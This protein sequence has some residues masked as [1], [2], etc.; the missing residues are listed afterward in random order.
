[1]QPDV[2]LGSFRLPVDAEQATERRH[3][4]DR[5]VLS[6]RHVQERGIGQPV[7]RDERHAALHAEVRAVR[8][9]LDALDEHLPGAGVAAEDESGDLLSARTRHT[10]EP[11]DLSRGDV[12]VESPDG[13]TTEPA[14][15]QSGLLFGSFDARPI[16]GYRLQGAERPPDREFD[17]LGL[18]ESLGHLRRDDG[19][20]TQHGDPFAD[21]EDLAEVV[22]HVDQGDPLAMDHPQHL[23]ESVDLRGGERGC[24]LVEDEDARLLLP[25]LERP[26]NGN[27]RA[28]GGRQ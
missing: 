10:C 2:G 22:G 11:H 15:A 6:Q 26:R 5:R 1:M 17:Q 19:A 9:H 13:L 8:R 20:V 27:S 4:A 24:G 14:H 12:Q 28:L 18:V 23:E 21:V 25:T 7:R 16:F 3:A